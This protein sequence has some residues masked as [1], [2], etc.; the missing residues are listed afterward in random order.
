METT[1]CEWEAQM[2]GRGVAEKNPAQARER[3]RRR[4]VLVTEAGPHV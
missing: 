4:V 1:T 3:R 2:K